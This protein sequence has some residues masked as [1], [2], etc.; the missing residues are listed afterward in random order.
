[1]SRTRSI[2]SVNE[3]SSRDIKARIVGNALSTVRQRYHWEGNVFPVVTHVQKGLRV[4]GV[5]HL[6][7]NPSQDW[8]RKLQAFVQ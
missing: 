4:I 7:S 1:M 6:R 8:N 5:K 3:M 2:P